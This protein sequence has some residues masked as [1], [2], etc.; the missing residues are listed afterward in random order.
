M[1]NKD[2]I[3]KSQTDHN[4]PNDNIYEVTYE[5]INTS[6]DKDNKESKKSFIVLGSGKNISEAFYN[7]NNKLNKKQL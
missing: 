2:G 3:I 1:S 6:I 5:V 7:T 4:E